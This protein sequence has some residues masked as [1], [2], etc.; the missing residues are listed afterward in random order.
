MTL[1]QRPEEYEEI[2]FGDTDGKSLRVE[3][4]KQ[5]QRLWGQ[6]TNGIFQ[7]DFCLISIFYK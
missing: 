7:E 2:S 1:D 3:G 5:V 4:E 6:F